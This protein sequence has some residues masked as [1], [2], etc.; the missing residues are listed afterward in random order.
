MTEIQDLIKEIKDLKNQVKI[1][2]ER[3]DELE[4]II[5]DV[6]TDEVYP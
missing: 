5:T 2:E 3:V 1:S 4:D 6:P